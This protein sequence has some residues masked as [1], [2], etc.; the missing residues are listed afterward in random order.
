MLAEELLVGCTITVGYPPDEADTEAAVPT[1]GLLELSVVVKELIGEAGTVVVLAATEPVPGKA[2]LEDELP[3]EALDALGTGR[4][5]LELE[6]LVDK[7]F[8]DVDT[9]DDVEGNTEGALL[10]LED[11]EPDAKGVL[12]GR[13]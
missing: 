13:V 4:V 8:G 6:A 12:L 3:V 9:E 1:A 5:L 2:D 7:L 11:D 10:E